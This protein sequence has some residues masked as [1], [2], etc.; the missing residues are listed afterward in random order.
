MIDGKTVL[1]KVR[2]GDI[3]SSWQVVRPRGLS[4]IAFGVLLMF[5]Y[6]ALI[7]DLN[8]KSSQIAKYIPIPTLT[9]NVPAGSGFLLTTAI[10]TGVLVYTI[11]LYMR[12]R[13]RVLVFTPDG[14]VNG[15]LRT[16]QIKI[17]MAYKDIDT[18]TLQQPGEGDFEP[19]SRVH[20]SIGDYQGHTTRWTIEEYFAI[21]A[22]EIA[23]IVFTHSV[24]A[25]TSELEPAKRP[26]APDPQGIVTAARQ[27]KLPDNWRVYTPSMPLTR[28]V[29][30][31]VIAGIL[32]FFFA[33]FINSYFI[34]GPSLPQRFNSGRPFGDVLA[35]ELVTLFALIFI[36]WLI[37]Y[38]EMGFWRKVLVSRNQIIVSPAAMVLANKR[39]GKIDQVLDYNAIS[40]L[41]VSQWLKTYTLRFRDSSGK[42][43]LIVLPSESLH[44]PAQVCQA[45]LI[46]YARS[47]AKSGLP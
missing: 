35:G 42:R 9:W 21:Q 10:L 13:A 27:G 33:A 28:Y 6:Y 36:P 47:R 11:W 17:S 46:R 40:D 3:P 31:L 2:Q 12:N 45:F 39:T 24:R 22:A 25:N 43:R 18:L 41:H 30:P 1:D 16:G 34:S 7:N 38:L 15:H 20:L 37:I 44:S 29:G 14:F 5:G 26:G 19:I 32:V 4:F 23:R 8:S